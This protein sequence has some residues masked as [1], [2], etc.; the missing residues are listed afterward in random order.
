MKAW[1]CKWGCKKCKIE[2]EI[3]ACGP[4]YL[5][6]GARGGSRAAGLVA[7]LGQAHAVALRRGCVGVGRG[8]RRGEGSWL[9]VREER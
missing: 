6:H 5:L 7:P 3:T 8:R 2:R 1:L 4:V 9:R